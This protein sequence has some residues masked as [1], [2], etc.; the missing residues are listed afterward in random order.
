MDNK[1]LMKL[2][3][4]RKCQIAFVCFSLLAFFAVFTLKIKKY[5]NIAHFIWK[6]FH[7]VYCKVGVFRCVCNM[8]MMAYS[9]RNPAI[10]YVLYC[11][12]E[13]LQTDLLL[14]F[15][16]AISSTV[17]NFPSDTCYLPFLPII[18][19]IIRIHLH[20]I[21]QCHPY[22]KVYHSRMF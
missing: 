22:S 13:L 19:Q 2:R 18:S 9:R 5:E 15:A 10:I 14:V 20:G 4:F 7:K 16:D 8:K 11:N 3:L 1:F 6:I 21:A 17:Y 12:L